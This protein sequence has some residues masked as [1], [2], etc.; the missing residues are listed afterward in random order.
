MVI[1]LVVVLNQLSQSAGTSVEGNFRELS[2][3]TYSK[4]KAAT[5][6]RL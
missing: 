1:N 2:P 6:S 3:T 4:I 5:N